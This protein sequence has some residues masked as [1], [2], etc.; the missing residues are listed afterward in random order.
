MDPKGLGL[1]GR[2]RVA[3]C[4]IAGVDPQW[5]V[6]NGDPIAFIVEVNAERRHLTTGQRAMAVAIGLVEAGARSNGRFQRG[7]VPDDTSSS[8]SS[9]VQAVWRAGLVLDHAPEL[10]DAVLRGD[11][12]LDGAHKQADERRDRTVRIAELDE[13]LAALVQ[14]GVV[15]LEEAEERVAAE[16]RIAALPEDLA[17]RINAGTLTLDE[18]ETIA[19]E[20]HDRI[21]A[22]AARIEEAMEH[23]RRMVGS[24][25]PDDLAAELTGQTKDSLPRV[26]NA[27]EGT[28]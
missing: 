14:A 18:A 3:A 21:V 28:P 25:I 13:Q 23:L 17:A 22:W 9:W 27:L 10:A 4:A 8:R 11:M 5:Q 19:S 6:Y 24:P 16:A 7:S 26:L 2:N 15:D 12:A 1:D 20:R